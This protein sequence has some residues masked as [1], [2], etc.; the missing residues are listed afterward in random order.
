[1]GRDISD[2]PLASPPR[3]AAHDEGPSGKHLARRKI[4]DCRLAAKIAAMAAA[5]TLWLPDGVWTAE[6]TRPPT[7]CDAPIGDV[8]ATNF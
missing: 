6:Q 8:I 5:G 7:P 3:A 4:T 1:M 2:H